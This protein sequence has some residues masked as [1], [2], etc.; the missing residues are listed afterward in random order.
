V[1]ENKV[2]CALLHLILPAHRVKATAYNT[3]GADYEAP[4]RLRD[5]DAMEVYIGLTSMVQKRCEAGTGCFES[6][7]GLIEWWGPQI[8]L[9]YK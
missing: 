2:F 7:L 8:S 6:K 3:T 9:H 4:S 5:E 1:H